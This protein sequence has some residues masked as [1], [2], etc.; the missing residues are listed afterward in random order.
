MKSLT[1]VITGKIKET[2]QSE[3]VAE[4]NKAL[5]KDTSKADL[6]IKGVMHFIKANPNWGARKIVE[7]FNLDWSLIKDFGNGISKIGFYTDESQR[8]S[9]MELNLPTNE[10][11]R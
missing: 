10:W 9:V 4:S 11:F 5:L 8:F 6:I 2:P 3:I 1:D 7:K